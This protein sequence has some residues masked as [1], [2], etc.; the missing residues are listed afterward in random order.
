MIRGGSGTPR[1][2]CAGNKN[3]NQVSRGPINLADSRSPFYSSMNSSGVISERVRSRPFLRGMHSS[4]L[5]DCA[6]ESYLNIH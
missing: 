6:I 2:Q 1:V 5:F 3:A 4:E